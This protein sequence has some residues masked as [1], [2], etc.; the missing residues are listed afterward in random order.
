VQHPVLAPL[1]RRIVPQILAMANLHTVQGHRPMLAAY[2]WHCS[3]ADRAPTP[4]QPDVHLGHRITIPKSTSDS[5]C[6]QSPPTHV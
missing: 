1:Y 4:T 2:L 5:W 3:A 6:L